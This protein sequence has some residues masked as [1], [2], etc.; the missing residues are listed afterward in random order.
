MS[1][2]CELRCVCRVGVIEKRS[3]RCFLISLHIRVSLS[4]RNGKWKAI[5][6]Y[7]WERWN[8]RRK[9]RNDKHFQAL[10][11]ANVENL[12]FFSLSLCDYHC[13]WNVWKWRKSALFSGLPKCE[14][15]P[16]W[17][18]FFLGRK[19]LHDT[20]DFAGEVLTPSTEC[21]LFKMV[22]AHYFQCRRQKVQ[23][24]IY[25]LCGVRFRLRSVFL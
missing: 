18:P 11:L 17:L 13:E 16:S 9:W 25:S 22:F 8:K 20:L 23:Q 1:H 4:T 24:Q 14:R 21:E 12:N 2:V 15:F 5:V 3:S 19:Y 10:A 6:I 7:G